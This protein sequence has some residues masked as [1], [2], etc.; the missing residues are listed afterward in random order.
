[1][2]STYD[3]LDV[4]QS[5]LM[6]RNL[7]RFPLRLPSKIT[8][9]WHISHNSYSGFPRSIESIELWN[10]FSKPWKSIDF[11]NSTISL[12]KFCSSLLILL[13][14]SELFKPLLGRTRSRGRCWFAIRLSHRPE[15]LSHE[16]HGA[17]DGLDIGGQQ[18][19][20]FVL[21]SDT[22]RYGRRQRGGQWFPAPPKWNL[23]AP[24]S[25]MAPWLLHTSN[26]VL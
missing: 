6:L 21:L 2:G 14:L 1:M 15:P 26:I 3:I 10:R 24:I 19:R 5:T 4:S 22:H 18:G 17:V 12:F 9:N 8:L 11:L 13:L 20:R 7:Q 16:V 23:C 25:R